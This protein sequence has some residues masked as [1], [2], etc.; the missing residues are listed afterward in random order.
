MLEP[1]QVDESIW[2][3]AEHLCQ[4]TNAMTMTYSVSSL[5]S[6]R[7]G[8]K[9]KTGSCAF[10]PKFPVCYCHALGIWGGSGHLLRCMIFTGTFE[11]SSLAALS[12]SGRYATPLHDLHLSFEMLWMNLAAT[13]HGRGG[14][15]MLSNKFSDDLRAGIRYKGSALAFG[16]G[17][18]TPDC[19]VLRT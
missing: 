19:P 4:C 11:S 10:G 14:V 6:R 16:S 15:G 18:V 9:Q 17:I 12:D 13:L 7:G 1:R 2:E 3:C 8:K 5:C